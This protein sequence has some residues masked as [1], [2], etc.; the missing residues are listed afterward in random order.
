MGGAVVSNNNEGK[1]DHKGECG[2]AVAFGRGSYWI[3]SMI[4]CVFQNSWMYHMLT[5]NQ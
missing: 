3:A 2:A 4:V 1:A 5:Y